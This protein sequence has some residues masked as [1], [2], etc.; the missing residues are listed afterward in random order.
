MP[1][2]NRRRRLTVLE[3]AKGEALPGVVMA[4]LLLAGLAARYFGWL[5]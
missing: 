2:F 1:T 4:V 3:Q 5:S